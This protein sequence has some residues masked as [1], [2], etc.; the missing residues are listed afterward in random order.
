[1]A[2]SIVALVEVFVFA[3]RFVNDRISMGAQPQLNLRYGGIVN[4]AGRDRAIA[5]PFE[6]RKMV[7][8]YTRPDGLPAQYWEDAMRVIVWI[9]LIFIASCDGDTRDHFYETHAAA[10]KQGEVR[11]DG[12]I[13]TYLPSSI[14]SIRVRYNIDS[15]E[16]WVSF[17]W[18]GKDWGA[19]ESRCKPE[20]LKEDQFPRR[21]PSSWPSELKQGASKALSNAEFMICGDGYLALQAASR[22]GFY[23]LNAS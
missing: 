15:N 11:D 8:S 2:P 14:N 19:I 13:P 22:R 17:D 16:V 6:S 23:W 7:C 4:K 1:M 9:A 12:P 3:P 20:V 21:V 10:V 5:R 18:D